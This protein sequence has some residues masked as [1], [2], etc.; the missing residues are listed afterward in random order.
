[1]NKLLKLISVNLM[2]LINYNGVMKEIEA[3]IKGKNETS[4]Y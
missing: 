2:A 1:M 4:N 3:G